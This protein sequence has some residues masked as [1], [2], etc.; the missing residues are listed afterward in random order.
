VKV[1]CIF[2]LS[3][4][5]WSNRGDQRA[6]EGEGLVAALQN[7]MASYLTLLYVTILFLAVCLMAGLIEPPSSRLIVHILGFPELV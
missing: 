7:W 3:K 2:R 1:F 4:Q 6:G 5:R